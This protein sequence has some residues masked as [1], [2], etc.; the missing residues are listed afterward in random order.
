MDAF[1]QRMI[2]VD[3]AA[4]VAKFAPA[5]LAFSDGHYGEINQ[6]ISYY[7][8]GRLRHAY[9]VAPDERFPR[10]GPP[11]NTSLNRASSVAKMRL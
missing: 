1:E 3:G 10:E 7:S 2:D 8:T 11:N 6:D 9:T 4:L 5:G